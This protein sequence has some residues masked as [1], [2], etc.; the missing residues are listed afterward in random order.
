MILLGNIPIVTLDKIYVTPDNQNILFLDC[1]RLDGSGLL[2]SRNNADDFCS[3]NSQVRN[4]S[5]LLKANNLEKIVLADDVVFSGS[6]LTTIINLFKKYGVEV[7]G[8]RSAVSTIMSYDKFNKKLPLGIKCGFLLGDN[9]IDQICER[10]FYF[11]IVQS[12]ISV[13]GDDN[14]IYK[15]PYF[16]P[17]GNP[18][19]RA[20]IPKEYET[21]F[22]NGCLE[23][24]IELWDE[25]ERL[26]DKTFFVRDLP[27]RIINANENDEVIKVLK[28]GVK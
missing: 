9:V 10:D 8:I 4:I 16:K 24:S 26:S 23:R 25:I 7:V 2:V 21:E 14:S 28:K 19:E 20:S 27:E 22:S 5:N 18:I 15:A 11:G 12:G 6:V 1:T 13:I 3:V 17:F